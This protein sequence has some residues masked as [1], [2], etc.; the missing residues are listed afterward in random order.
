MIN[1]VASGGNNEKGKSVNL[2]IFPVGSLLMMIFMLKPMVRTKSCSLLQP[3]KFVVVYISIHPS[4]LLILL[5]FVHICL[6]LF[7]LPYWLT[8]FTKFC[9]IW[10]FE[11]MLDYTFKLYFCEMKKKKNI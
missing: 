8:H 11:Q 3:M 2:Q 7:I 6:S 1:F 4:S 5:F 9:T 10:D